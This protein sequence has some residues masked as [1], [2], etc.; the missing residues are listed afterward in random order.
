MR[1]F[2]EQLIT[3][4]KHFFDSSILFLGTILGSLL[5]QIGYPKQ[6]VLIILF[7]CVADILTKWFSVTT[8]NCGRFSLYNMYKTWIL[9]RKLSSEKFRIGTTAKFTLYLILLYPAHQ[10]M[11]CE[12]EVIGFSLISSVI[13]TII[14]LIELSSIIE[15]FNDAGYTRLN[16]LLKWLRGKEN[17]LLEI[18]NDSE[19]K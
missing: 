15:N 19:N 1:L 8:I 2:F 3:S 5:A 18:D 17:D 12:N 13:Y 10:L 11:Y 9:D 4:G 6:I 7:L 16:G 14:L